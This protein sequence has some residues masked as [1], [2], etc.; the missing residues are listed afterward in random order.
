MYYEEG[1]KHRW[2]ECFDNEMEEISP[3]LVTA[4]L[5]PLF[6]MIFF[7]VEPISK[8]LIQL[9]ETFYDLW[10]QELLNMF[11]CPGSEI[12]TVVCDQKWFQ[13]VTNFRIEVE[14][15]GTL[16]FC[17]VEYNSQFANSRHILCT[18]CKL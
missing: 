17:R 11:F 9:H 14:F 12:I 7:T 6:L 18:H 5:D 3:N 15:L 10:W 1:G 2:L 13:K 4:N 16:S 8:G